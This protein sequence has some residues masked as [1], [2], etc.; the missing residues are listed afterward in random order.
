[1]PG[2]S[3]RNVHTVQE[4]II[5]TGIDKARVTGALKEHTP[6]KKAQKAS[7]IAYLYVDTVHIHQLD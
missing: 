4:D 1:M 7:M 3:R 5:K 6:E 2:K